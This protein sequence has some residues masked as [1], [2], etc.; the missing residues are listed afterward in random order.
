MKG[1]SQG[2]VLCCTEG[3]TF[4]MAD[5]CCLTEEEGGWVCVSIKKYNMWPVHLTLVVS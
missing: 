1:G 4:C 2:N 3:K 5:S